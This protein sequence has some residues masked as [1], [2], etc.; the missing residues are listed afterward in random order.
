MLEKGRAR[1]WQRKKAWLTSEVIRLTEGLERV[2]VKF[3]TVLVLS[4]TS[5]VKILA[6]TFISS[7]IL[8]K[9]TSVSLCSLTCK[10]RMI[11]ELA[12]EACCEV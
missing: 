11:I 8:S 4:W 6:P 7:V 1:A 2:S 12:L 5:R 10:M 3:S 9:W